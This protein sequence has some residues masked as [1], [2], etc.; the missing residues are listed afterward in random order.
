MG[1]VRVMFI[2]IAGITILSD[3]QSAQAVEVLLSDPTLSGLP[4]DRCLRDGR[5]RCSAASREYVADQVCLAQGFQRA[6]SRSVAYHAGKEQPAWIFDDK[7]R[8]FIAGTGT[9]TIT[10]VRCLTPEP[11]ITLTSPANGMHVDAAPDSHSHAHPLLS[12][13]IAASLAWTTR[14]LATAHSVV[15]CLQ[16]NHQFNNDQYECDTEVASWSGN[17][18]MIVYPLEY[19]QIAPESGRSLFWSVRACE[20]S[21]TGSLTANGARYSC[22]NWATPRRL[23]IRR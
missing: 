3:P 13:D 19:S 18:R 5:G 1:V 6:A 22:T 2:A 11:A 10:N 14:N 7:T 12:D 21:A 16:R 20:P 4:F 17:H 15:G 23:N 9:N 8:R